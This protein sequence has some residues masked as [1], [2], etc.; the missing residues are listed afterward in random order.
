V[1]IEVLNANK[2]PKRE[3]NVMQELT[4]LHHRNIMGYYG[5]KLTLE[6]L[7]LFLEYCGGGTLS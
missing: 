5:C 2:S 7:Y 6:G 1:R 4:K 3:I